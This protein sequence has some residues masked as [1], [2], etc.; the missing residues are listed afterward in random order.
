ME[1]EDDGRGESSGGGGGGG[2]AEGGAGGV[3]DTKRSG[4]A[5]LRHGEDKRQGRD[6]RQRVRSRVRRV[7]FVRSGG[8]DRLAARR[9]PG[10]CLLFTL[11][12]CSCCRTTTQR[13]VGVSW[14]TLLTANMSTFQLT[15]RGGW[16]GGAS[17]GFTAKTNGNRARKDEANQ[18]FAFRLATT[19]NQRRHEKSG[20]FA[21]C[22]FGQRRTSLLPTLPPFPP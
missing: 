4:V 9:A 12:L 18:S 16:V 21:Y 19:T 14:C 11:D 7:S 3:A 1:V 10:G 2:R 22:R 5:V 8:D 13:G 6:G 17:L 15:H 20:E